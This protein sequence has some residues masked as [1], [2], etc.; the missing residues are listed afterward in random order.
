MPNSHIFQVNVSNGGVPKTPVGKG[1]V[2]RLGLEGDRQRDLKHHGG[3]QRALCL[4]PLEAI[5]ELQQKGH[6]IYPGAIGENVTIAGLDWGQV[7]PGVELQLGT[8]VRVQITDYA[9]PCSNIEAAFADGNINYV[10]AKKAP[11]R[12]RV[13]ARVIQEG[14]IRP[15]DAVTLMR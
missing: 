7:V 15:G 9:H 5:L 12:A 1:Q 11:H 8:E 2:T 14:L 4:F 6:P 10:S 13:Y 3:S